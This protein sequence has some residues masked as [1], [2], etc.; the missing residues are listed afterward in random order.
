MKDKHM[1]KTRPFN[2][3]TLIATVCVATSSCLVAQAQEASTDAPATVSQN[4]PAATPA[5]DQ[6]IA[7]AN[8]CSK[9]IGAQVRDSQGNVLGK[10]DDIVVDYN[11]GRVSY[12]ALKVDQPQLGGTKYL[13]IPLAAFRPSGDGQYFILNADKE[14]V[15]QARGFNRNEWPAMTDVAWGAQAT[16]QGTEVPADQGQYLPPVT[17]TGAV[18]PDLNS[19]TLPVPPADANIGNQAL[20]V[21][22]SDQVVQSPTGP[23]P[24]FTHVYLPGA[25]P[26]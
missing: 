20:V 1:I 4:Q 15:A 25:V 13:A 2:A 22:Q 7:R 16:P 10:I 5:P 12:C 18:T 23:F 14:K 24:T 26:R 11:T 8:K 6:Q 19:A 3:K 17:V 9:L 21:S